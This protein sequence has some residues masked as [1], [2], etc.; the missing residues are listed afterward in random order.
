MSPLQRLSP[1]QRP[2]HYSAPVKSGPGLRL[3]CLRNMKSRYPASPYLASRSSS[4]CGA[5]SR[6]PPAFRAPIW[7]RT[8][9]VT[10]TRTTPAR[11]GSKPNPRPDNTY[12]HRRKYADG[13]DNE[14]HKTRVARLGKEIA[15]LGNRERA[16]KHGVRIRFHGRLSL[17]RSS[18]SERKSRPHQH[19]PALAVWAVLS[20]PVTVPITL[21]FVDQNSGTK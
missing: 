1:L 13:D 6:P 15:N 2:L 10:A 21:R 16:G 18:T 12:G 14:D 5:F 19:W 9:I 20:A 11:T 8:E 17:R 7:C 4:S 3:P